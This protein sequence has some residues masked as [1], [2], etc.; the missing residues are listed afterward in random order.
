M[1]TINSF[2]AF[3]DLVSFHLDNATRQH[4]KQYLVRAKE[5]SSEE[6]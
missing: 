2:N 6:I 3:N 5:T 4:V 1:T